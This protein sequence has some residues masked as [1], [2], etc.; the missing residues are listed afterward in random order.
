VMTPGQAKIDRLL[1]FFI[2]QTRLF[3]PTNI[4]R[5]F[6]ALES[7]ANR[8]IYR[9]RPDPSRRRLSSTSTI[10]LST[11]DVGIKALTDFPLLGSVYRKDLTVLL[12]IVIFS[13]FRR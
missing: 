13:V 8:D 9:I 10:P 11:S 2:R 4:E 7:I 12:N 5:I 6:K 3:A 1:Y